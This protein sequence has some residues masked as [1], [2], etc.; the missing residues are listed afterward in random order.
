MISGDNFMQGGK[1]SCYSYL[2]CRYV[3][4]W[5]WA[6]WRRA[7]QHYDVDLRLWKTLRGTRFLED[8]LG[9]GAEARLWRYYFDR[10]ITGESHTWDH[11]WQF[12]C[13]L[14][15]GLSV[16]PASNL[17]SNI[18]FSKTAQHYKEFNPKLANVAAVEMEFPLRH[19]PAIVRTI[20]AD[21][22]VFRELHQ[23]PC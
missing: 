15:D 11:Q 12:A 10:I 6:T 20:E 8:F 23:Q 1:L 18:G 3:G 22:F 4:I 5:G 2:F 21:D 19:P 17:V 13:W 16:M 7:W 9:N 14:Q